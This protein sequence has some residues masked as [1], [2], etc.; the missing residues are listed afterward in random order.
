MIKTQSM[1]LLIDHEDATKLKNEYLSGKRD[2][3]GYDLQAVDMRE[4]NLS[5]ANLRDADLRKSDL[6]DSNLTGIDLSGA[7][8]S[9]INLENA[10]LRGAS[11]QHATLMWASLSEANLQGA[12]LSGVS[13]DA[14]TL[15]KTNLQG[16]DLS[17][18]YLCGLDLSEANLC[19]AY[20]SDSTKFDPEFDPLSAGM[21]TGVSI[22]IENIL[23]HLNALSKYSSHYLGNKIITKYW[24]QSRPDEPWLEQFQFDHTGRVSYADLSKKSINL[25]QLNL[26]QIWI[27]R[28]IDNCAHV[29]QEL[30]S[31]ADRHNLL[32]I[33]MPKS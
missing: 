4:S 18:A 16:A 2:F 3:P 24:E 1:R 33:D 7:N 28:F 21:Q 15:H 6:R 11:C 30:P 17:D 32:I 27:N 5:Y 12:D 29:F 31:I 10:D 23:N 22:N 19:G 9:G 8:L 14:A 25:I 26:T 20:F 13:F